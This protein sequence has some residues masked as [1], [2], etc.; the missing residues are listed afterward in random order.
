M[1]SLLRLRELEP[2]LKHASDQEVAVI[3]E[4]L[5]EA[6]QLAY[7]S[8]QDRNDSKFALGSEPIDAD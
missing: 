2:K 3:R 7:D 8:Y 1:I 4:K 6:A 5:Y